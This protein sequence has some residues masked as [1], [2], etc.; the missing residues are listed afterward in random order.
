M[1]TRITLII[2]VAI[3]V[4]TNL[5]LTFVKSSL[6]LEFSVF[7]NGVMMPI[8]TAINIFVFVKLTNAISE[9]DTIRSEK[10]MFFQRQLML[11]QFRKTEIDIFEK[12]M[13]DVFSFKSVSDYNGIKELIN[14]LSYSV[15]NAMMYL[16]SFTNTKLSMFDLNKDSEIAVD[17]KNYISLLEKYKNC[18]EDEKIP[19]KE[20]YSKMFMLKDSIIYSLQKITLNN[21]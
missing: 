19:P 15:L 1:N 4:V 18:L 8:L 14:A 2:T 17:I 16:D 6:W 20:E 7:F 12:T 10:E 13:D 11:M 21:D 5:F 9:K 3:L